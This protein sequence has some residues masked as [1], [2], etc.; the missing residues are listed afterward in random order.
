[1][2][3]NP[4]RQERLDAYR[5]T[6]SDVVRA[7]RL[8]TPG[9]VL[10]IALH[11]LFISLEQGRDIVRQT[12]ETPVR[13]GLLAVATLFLA[14]VVWYTA[15]LTA[16]AHFEAVRDHRFI[17]RTVP[18]LLG[19]S[20]FSAVLVAF[21]R[22]G[23]DLEVG[24]SNSEVLGLILAE[25][26][27]FFLL[28]AL[29]ERLEKKVGGN[30]RRMLRI[31]IALHVVL[32]L[33][34]IGMCLEGATG[35]T[36]RRWPVVMII[37]MQTAFTLLMNVRG[38][39]VRALNPKDAANTDPGRK[40]SLFDRFFPRQ[41]ELPL[42]DQEEVLPYA[43]ERK[44]YVVFNVISAVVL[45]LMI[46]VWA[47]PGAARV[48][49]PFAVVWFSA[50][51]LMGA[52]NFKARLS[53]VLGVPLGLLFIGWVLV[54]GLCWDH[55]KVH[56]RP[57]AAGVA[58]RSTFRQHLI[59][60][61]DANVPADTDQR[62][63]VPMI[64]VLADGGASRSGYWAARVLERLDREDRTFRDRLF[65]LSGASG[66]AVGIASYYQWAAHHPPG[67]GLKAGGFPD[68][69]PLGQDMLSATLANM[70]GPDLL[71]LFLPVFRDRARALE[72]ALEL[73]DTSFAVPVR[74][75]FAPE[76]AARRPVLCLNTTRLDD[77]QPG[78]VASVRTAEFTSRIDVLDLMADPEDMPLS[79]AMVL[80]SRFP[81][82]SPAGYLR[83]DE[84]KH[85]FVDGG[86][87]DNSGAGIV[88]EMLLYLKALAME[89]GWKERIA[90]VRPV[91]L[92]LSNTAPARKED[93]TGVHP[94]ANDA[95]AP[96]LTVLGTYGAQTN[97]NDQRLQ[98]Y[99]CEAFDELAVYMDINLY[100][101]AS[102][103]EYS[104]SWSVSRLM[105]D[106][107]DKKAVHHPVADTFLRSLSAAEP[108]S[109][110]LK[111]GERPSPGCAL[112]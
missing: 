14:M 72:M 5:R 60:W 18:R 103:E 84:K 21:L 34:V 85:Y 92:H 42:R 49:G 35:T 71:N 6:V 45:A 69:Q 26:G 89:P 38:K 25:V 37:V 1:M 93:H 78:V 108:W 107:M 87:F 100:Q 90:Q 53:Q 73:A 88:Q 12:M 95:A 36:S 27:F 50:G 112:R 57:T 17:R 41:L 98:R 59:A 32:W 96:L 94:L 63:P 3:A 74:Q 56:T 22:T 91:V 81:Y 44:Y 7:L 48:I 8:F 47:W 77:G 16:F 102:Q 104:M 54:I 101:E 109:W 62:A 13:L 43:T 106:R 75:L 24:A 31:L 28:H 66:G 97:I 29:S 11:V 82:V 2:T 39:W 23:S 111:P 61:L 99:L 110:R 30:T 15:R 65:C 19:F 46:F 83:I 9:Y 76:R 79:T 70:L 67:T 52:F 55:H 33:M 40:A 64:F 20:C 4:L 80:S 105:A 86:Y 51:L 58:E 68:A 10:V